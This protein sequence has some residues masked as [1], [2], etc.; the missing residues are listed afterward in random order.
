MIKTVLLSITLV[1]FV[2]CGSSG[3]SSS[4][5]VSSSSSDDSNIIQT[6]VAKSSIPMLAVLVSYNNVQ[7]SS[8]TNTWSQKLFG[9]SEGEL[10]HYY[11]QASSGNFEFTPAENGNSVVENGTVALQLYKNHPDINIDNTFFFDNEVHSDLKSTLVVLDDYIDFSNYDADANG[12][13]TP[14]ELLLT[15]IIAGY[16]DSYEGAHVTNGIWAHQS[17]IADSKNIPVLDSVTLMS[18]NDNGNF[19]L[20]GELHDA[21]NPHDATIGIIAHELGHSAFN[22]PDLY[23]TSNQYSGGIGVFGL[24]GAGTWTTKSIYE[25]P[26]ETPT[27]FSAWSKVYNRWITPR[28]E[29]AT[30]TTLSATSSADYD[31]IKI[32]INSSSYYLLENRANSGYDEGLYTLDGNF[33]GGLAIWK[34]DNSK[35]TENH[36][37]NNS[38][39]SDTNNKGVDLVEAYNGDIDSNGGYGNARAL[40]YTGNKN[41]FLN[42]VSDISQPGSTMSLN[43][44]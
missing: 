32:P 44:N 27:H 31:I 41:Y 39:N 20:F 15:F 24:M 21:Q 42:L 36:F 7:I 35:L 8:S 14:D 25:H 29:S 9:K 13:I 34:I 43:I 10:N 22:L 37:Y 23:N 26:G 18:C 33:Q 2:G 16:E 19:A 40:Y 12:A 28:V 38:V 3:G 17:C 6:T 11:I 4:S 30:S 5:P 1:L